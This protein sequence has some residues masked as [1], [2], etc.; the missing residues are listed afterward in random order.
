MNLIHQ[1]VVD[2][3]GIDRLMVKAGGRDEC[4]IESEVS[5]LYMGEGAF[6]DRS[7]ARG[8]GW[9]G[10]GEVFYTQFQNKNPKSGGLDGVGGTCGGAYFVPS[11]YQGFP[12]S[13]FDERLDRRWCSIE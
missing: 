12:S 11:F 4:G 9:G 6:G 1:H 5:V 10:G 8:S 3:R 2:T 7:Y 13:L